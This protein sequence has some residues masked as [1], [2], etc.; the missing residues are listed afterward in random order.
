MSLKYSAFK[1][2]TTSIRLGI[3]TSLILWFITFSAIIHQGKNY[4]ELPWKVS[5][6]APE[7]QNS[8]IIY[9]DGLD[10]DNGK[11]TNFPANNKTTV[12]YHKSHSNPLTP[13]I[14]NHRYTPHNLKI[15]NSLSPANGFCEE[16]EENTQ[17]QIS[18]YQRLSDD[19]VEMVKVLIDHLENDEPFSGLRDFFQGKLANFDEDLLRKHFFK[20]AG[21]SVWLEEYGVHLMV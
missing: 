1:L 21:T 10:H 4:G 18:Q 19:F 8:I 12:Q 2:T 3:I 6:S 16:I 20:F 14:M 17:I 9:P 13:E 15:Y 7:L 11:L 5:P